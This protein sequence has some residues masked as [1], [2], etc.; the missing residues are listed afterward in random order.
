MIAALI[1]LITVSLILYLI[2]HNN[3][4]QGGQI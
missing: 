1:S 3:N 4:R 2:F